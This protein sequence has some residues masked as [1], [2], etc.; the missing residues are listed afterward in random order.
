MWRVVVVGGEEEG[1][2][3][4][5]GLRG[6][7]TGV[8]RK[9]GG[10]G[11][12]VGGGGWG[13][14]RMAGLG[15]EQLSSYVALLATAARVCPSSRPGVTKALSCALRATGKDESGL[16]RS[17]RLLGLGDTLLRLGCVEPLLAAIEGWAPHTDASSVRQFVGETLALAG[18]PY[19]TQFASSLLR[20]CRLG[21]GTGS[22]K[23][24]ANRGMDAFLDELKRTV[25]DK[26]LVLGK[27]EAEL[28]QS[29][30]PPVEKKEV[31]GFRPGR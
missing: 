23:R 13:S 21:W 30:S 14:G 17:Q 26:S 8:V 15:L 29:F 28:L 22:M 24:G 16:V 11:V 12:G 6:G 31:S 27:V 7:S 5:G 4:G 9:G 3:G 18:P 10:G 19:S 20:L 2:G 25:A 1:G